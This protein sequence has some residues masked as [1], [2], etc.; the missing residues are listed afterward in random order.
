MYWQQWTAPDDLRIKRWSLDTGPSTL[1]RVSKQASSFNS[2]YMD[3]LSPAP[4]SK[5]FFLTERTLRENLVST[6]IASGA[7]RYDIHFGRI[8]PVV[9]YTSTG[10]SAYLVSNA[11][12]VLNLEE[13]RQIVKVSS[14]LP[15]PQAIRNPTWSPDGTKLAYLKGRSVYVADLEKVKRSSGRKSAARE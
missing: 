11:L 1:L 13:G 8:E 5:Y 12:S 2:P 10:T 9:N 15:W 4:G 6:L 14:P 3:L 7:E